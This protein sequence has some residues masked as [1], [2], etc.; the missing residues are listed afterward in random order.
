MKGCSV[1]LV[2]F[3]LNVILVISKKKKKIENAN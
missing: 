3:I 1:L 2:N